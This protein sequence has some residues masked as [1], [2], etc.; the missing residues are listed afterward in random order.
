MTVIYI[1]LALILIF[2]LANLIHY[3][4]FKHK[5][6]PVLMYHRV[7]DNTRDNRIRYT[8]HKGSGLDIDS[9]KVSINAFQRQLDYLIRKNY[10]TITMD[11]YLDI[12]NNKKKGKFVAIT[13]DDGYED[14]YLYA[15]P[16]LL[17]REMK[18]TIYLVTNFINS[19][20]S[21]PIDKDD[22]FTNNKPLTWDEVREMNKNHIT[23]GAHT[24]NHQFLTEIN[25]IEVLVQEIVESK[26]KIEQ[27]LNIEVKSFAYPA[28][29]YNEEIIRIVQEHYEN[30]VITANGRIVPLFNHNPYLI[31]REAISRTDN[32]FM[33]KLKLW[34]IHRF[35][36]KSLW[37][38]AL[39]RLLKWR[40]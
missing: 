23:F 27:E 9:M 8:T 18:A 22:D 34:G 29:L 13:F 10:Q 31:E 39:R 3:L 28:G 17:E 20:N 4:L 35:I 24:L 25:D 40:K 30:A 33:F 15:Y 12:I 5:Y 16:L 7:N 19:N 37:Y 11:E 32:L 36:R 2:I 21:L 26:K 1:I 6:I 14:N 38:Q